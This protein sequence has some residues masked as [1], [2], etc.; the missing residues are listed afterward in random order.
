MR[1]SRAR[2]A[3]PGWSGDNDEAERDVGCLG[4]MLGSAIFGPDRDSRLAARQQ[5]TFVRS[6]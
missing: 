1:P 6:D 5:Y 4:D 2:L 3:E